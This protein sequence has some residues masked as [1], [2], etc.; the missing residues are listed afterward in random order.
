MTRIKLCGLRRESDIDAA[1]ELMADYVGFVF[2]EKSKRAVTR[3]RAVQ[4]RKRLAPG[5]W[6]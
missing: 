6:R 2:A 5:Y 1:N 3:E 4:L